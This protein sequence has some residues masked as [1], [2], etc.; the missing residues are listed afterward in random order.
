METIDLNDLDLP[1]GWG[2]RAFDGWPQLWET[3]D[4]SEPEVEYVEFSRTATFLPAQF[5]LTVTMPPDASAKE[6]AASLIM[7]FSVT[8][9]GLQL[10]G[11]A[12]PTTDVDLVL[13]RVKRAHRV[14]W[15]KVKAIDQLHVQKSRWIIEAIGSHSA[16]EVAKTEDLLARGR[17]RSLATPVGRRRNRVTS[18]MLD[19]VA[20][21]YL[22]ADDGA[23]TKAVASAMN[24]TPSRAAHLVVEARKRGKLPPAN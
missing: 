23:R 20:E 17:M 4:T 22:N 9:D 3:L 5:Q 2:C 6:D 10:A 7:F 1:D 19:T 18:E 21:T 14:D 11:A 12:S 13:A 8:D 24:V 15:W 16:G